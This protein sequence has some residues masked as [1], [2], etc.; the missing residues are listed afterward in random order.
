[1]DLESTVARHYGHAALE[2]AI[3]AALAAMGKDPDHLTPEDLAP[4]DE[5]HIGGRAATRDLADAM[6][7]AP[8]LALLDIGCGLGGAA[9]LFAGEFG[10]RVT[11]L[12]LTADYVRCAAALA[13]RVGLGGQAEF[14]QGSALAL[15]FAEAGFDAATL[16]HVGM[17]IADKAR[18]FAEARR[19]LR[20]GGVFG[21]YDVMREGEGDLA[22]PLPWA[23][24]A[25]TSF[26]EDADTY[27]RLL[28]A[29]GFAV[30]AVRS[31]RAFAIEFFRR[32][33]VAAAAA[34][35]PP[36]LGLHILMGETAPLKARNMLGNLEA[37]LIAPTEII[38]RAV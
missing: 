28:A 9:R 25:A 29:A 15:P 20:P 10:C 17:N 34:G 31:R 12:D 32:M 4:V 19:V 3:L 38:A 26:V 7:L 6:R 1:M 37:G 33:R 18:L 13:R 35:G 36:P 16:L 2:H 23:A 21:I 30:E 24:G 14:R 5:F 11:G 8:G 22:F 27:R